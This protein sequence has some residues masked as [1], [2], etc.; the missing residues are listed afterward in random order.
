ML[1]VSPLLLRQWWTVQC[2]LRYVSPSIADGLWRSWPL[3]T[4]SGSLEGVS[5]RLAGHECTLET[6][7]ASTDLE[8][9]A[10][11]SA[12]NRFSSFS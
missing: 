8:V 4:A 12:V 10:Y 2:V 1:H 11:L 3:Q 5:E 7:Q 6:G 9:P